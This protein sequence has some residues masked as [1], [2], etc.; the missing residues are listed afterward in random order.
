MIDRSDDGEERGH[1]GLVLLIYFP[2]LY[3]I[4]IYGLILYHLYT[5]YLLLTNFDLTDTPYLSIPDH[6]NSNIAQSTTLRV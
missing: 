5:R 2:F 6:P 4:H 1:F 3:S